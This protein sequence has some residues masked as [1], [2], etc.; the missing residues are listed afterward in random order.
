MHLSN[1]ELEGGKNPH[2]VEFLYTLV[3]MTVTLQ[4]ITNIALEKTSGP[5]VLP[6][7]ILLSSDNYIAAFII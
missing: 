1:L 6:R 5:C 7:G 2:T 4:K 3:C